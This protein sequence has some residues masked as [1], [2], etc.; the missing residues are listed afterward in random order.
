MRKKNAKWCFFFLFCIQISSKVNLNSSSVCI[1]SHSLV[2][3]LIKMTRETMS[4][5]FPIEWIEWCVSAHLW[6]FFH[7]INRFQQILT[8]KAALTCSSSF[9]SQQASHPFVKRHGLWFL[10]LHHVFT[11]TKQSAPL[12]AAHKTAANEQRTYANSL[13]ISHRG[14]SGKKTS[15]FWYAIIT[16]KLWKILEGLL[17]VSD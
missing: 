6:L 12:P 15:I 3:V 13:A 8:G 1:P 14:N 2:Y 10:T 17:H 11:A 7:L 4:C 5:C 9:T 16:V